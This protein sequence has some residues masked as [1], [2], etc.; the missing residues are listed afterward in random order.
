MCENRRG[1]WEKTQRRKRGGTAGRGHSLS[2][3]S[4]VREEEEAQL[5][6]MGGPEWLQQ[7][8]EEEKRSRRGEVEGGGV[9]S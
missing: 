9:K 8:T 5:Q 7:T 3:G 1:P 6:N 2:K 4:A